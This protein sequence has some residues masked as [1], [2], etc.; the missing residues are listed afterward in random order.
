MKKLYIILLILTNVIFALNIEFNLQD[1]K[2]NDV[3]ITVNKQGMHFD[4]YPN[5][6]ILLDFF[7]LGCPPCIA[8][9]PHLV[10]LQ[11]KYKADLQII[12]VEVQNRLSIFQLRKFFRQFK[13]NYTII[14][15]PKTASL[16]TF[17]SQITRWGGG[18]PFMLLIDEKGTIHTVYQGMISK[19]EL[20]HDVQ[21]LILKKQDKKVSKK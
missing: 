15:S 18:I 11:E 8:S 13:I 12:G 20:S 7:G 21:K 1:V 2:S 17:V 16:T 5:K 3:N 4:T 10:E 9:I 6:I 19:Y 14:N